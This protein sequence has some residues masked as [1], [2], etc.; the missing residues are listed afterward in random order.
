M[1]S[2][3]QKHP[4]H[5]G[6]SRFKGM[7]YLK[8]ALFLAVLLL[9]FSVFA[10]SMGVSNALNTLMNTAYRLL[11]D[12]V[13]YIMAIAVIAGAFSALM[14]EFGVIGLLNKL[15]SPLMGPLYGM[16]G[17][18][19]LGIVTTYFSD[20]PAILTLADD[21]QY[22]RYFK[23]WQ[24]PALT[25][26]GTAFGMGLIVSTFML[27]LDGGG[28][29][30]IGFAVLCGNLGAIIGSVLSTRLMLHFSAAAFRRDDLSFNPVPAAASD[31]PDGDG[32]Q[33]WLRV[34]NALMEG[35]KRGVQLGLG[36]IPGVLII[37]SVVLMLTNGTSDNGVYTGAAYEGIGLLPMV[38]NRLGFLLHP[39]FGF[40]TSTGIAVPVTALGSAGAA[41]GLVPKLVSA[42]QANGNDIAVFTAMCMCWSG[43]LSTHV[44]MM[45]VLHCNRL[46][47]KAIVSHALGGIAA[48]IAAHWLFQLSLPLL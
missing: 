11:M 47:S 39:L 28:E 45:D 18:A 21:P 27:G 13:L 9:F 14:Q 34:L 41:L 33:V 7:P 31:M 35:G 30:H 26:L 40:S 4:L 6:N 3:S 15:L 17:A 24:I 37:C 5:Y 19:A 42:G 25:N 22:R 36:I 12:T 29:M 38:A 43:Y 1:F 20:N 23:T 8:S 48:G 10:V 46:T 2:K 16:P 32:T 44:S